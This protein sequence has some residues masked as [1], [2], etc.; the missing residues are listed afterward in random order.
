[1]VSF[2]ALASTSLNAKSENDTPGFPRATKYLIDRGIDETL[3]I[4]LRLHIF[5]ARELWTRVY[6]T[7]RSND[8]RLAIVFP[9][10]D[11]SGNPID[12]WSARLVEPHGLSSVKSFGDLIEKRKSKMTCPPDVPPHAYLPPT[13][14]WRALK[15]GDRVYIHESAIKAVNGARMGTY[16][17]GLNGVWGWTSKKHQVRLVDEVRNLPWRKLALQPI[18]IFDSNAEDNWDVQNAIVQ[19]ASTLNDITGRHARHIL[20]PRHE[21]GSHQGFD[22]FVVRSAESTVRL[23]LEQEGS[24]VEISE[25]QQMK[26]ELNDRVVVVRSLCRI[27][28]QDTGTLMT[29]AAFTDVNY[30][31]YTVQEETENGFKSI[32]VPKRW[33]EDHRRSEVERID[34]VPGGERIQS[35]ALNLWRGLGV[36]PMPG[37]VEPFLGLLANNIPDPQL[38]VWLLRWL[39]YPLQNLGGKTTTFVHL[40]GPSGTGK[41][42]LVRPLLRIFGPNAVTIGKEQLE[43]AFNSVYAAKQLIHMDELHGGNE[44]TARKIYNKIKMLVSGETIVVNQKGQPE[45]E[46]R[47]H[48]NLITTSNYVDSIKLDDDDRR[49]AVIKFKPTKDRRNDEGYWRSY[50]DWCDGDGAAHL[51]D[52]LLKLDLG[53]FN[54]HAWAPETEEKQMVKSASK[55]AMEDWVDMLL[56]DPDSVVPAIYGA[57]ALFTPKELAIMYLGDPDPH[58]GQVIALGKVLMNKGLEK[59]DNGAAIKV[60]GNVYRYWIV[61][62]RDAKWTSKAIRDH[63]NLF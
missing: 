43:S 32:C 34:Y 52:Y 6:N 49:A 29:K 7:L 53:D 17:V 19:L 2:E 33:L 13:L 4:A 30:A 50:I 47:N 14:D 26:S 59:A 56:S 11:L 37:E 48:A 36:A 63:L 8:D 40:F 35:G 41:N 44:A 38:R 12:W 62:R 9:H 51:L 10:F 57:R 16:S 28:E 61:K 27:A 46:V 3:R 25:L 18:I 42:M 55:N 31:T 60:K 23:Y 15:K 22:D 24:E 54:P 58:P 21:D 1:M 39:A 5:P 45:Y 20:L